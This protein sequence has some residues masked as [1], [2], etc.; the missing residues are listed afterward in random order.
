[1]SFLRNP[2]IKASLLIY[3]FIDFI[4]I[5]SGFLF[6]ITTGIFVLAACIIFTF[7]HFI[8]T[9]RRYQKIINLSKNL[10]NLLHGVEIMSLKEYDEGEL[11]ILHSEI[12][13]LTF[14]LKEQTDALKKDK[15]YLADSIADISH[16]IRTPL[17][18]INLLLTLLSREDVTDKRRKEIMQELSILVSRID[19]LITVLLKIAK[20]DAGTV[21][22]K[23][24][25]VLVKDLISMASDPLLIPIEL[26][27]QE[28]IINCKGDESFTGD[29][30]WTA[31]A[32]GNVLKNCMEHTPNGGKIEILTSENAIFTEIIV[33]D[34]GRGISKED[35]PHLF[36]RFY[37]GSN[38]SEQSVGIGLSLSRLILARQNGTVKAENRKHGGARF[39]I[40]LYK[41]TV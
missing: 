34:N 19:W 32:L 28:L 4:L 10:N 14:A 16:Q 2:E 9:Y 29:K 6:G 17:T 25:K 5:V 37:K 21:N 8:I 27:E 36:E 1:M 39:I 13:K 35:L 31:E 22:F 15:I 40:R 23:S 3:L 30:S 26:R 7:L 41:S 33:C 11:S 20:L 12:S 24:E 18:S 38:S